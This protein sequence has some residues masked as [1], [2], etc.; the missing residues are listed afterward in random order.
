MA[1]LILMRLI[2]LD[3]ESKSIILPPGM[4]LDLAGIAKG[5]AVDR[6]A[7]ILRDH[8]V[9]R[10]MVNLGGNIYA[11]GSPPGKKGWS[12]G[13][14]DPRGERSVVGSLFL[15]D[16]AVATSGNY[17]NYIEIEGRTY[18]HIIDPRNGKPVSHMLSVTVVASS[19]LQADALS[20]GFFVL[21][22]EGSRSALELLK[23]IK[24]LFA[25][26]TGETVRYEELGDFMGTL[27]LDDPHR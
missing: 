2:M 19:A 5:Y 20:T 18:G 26:P 15:E 11:I 6:A 24:A 8:D 25:L 4:E 10:G 27:T 17:E 22:P 7:A 14:R 23:G 9:E 3:V 1:A 16:E 12:V 21:G 13:I